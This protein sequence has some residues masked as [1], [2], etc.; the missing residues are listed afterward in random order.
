MTIFNRSM[1][2]LSRISVIFLTLTFNVSLWAEET[3]VS[4][5]DNLVTDANARTESVEVGKHVMANMDAGSMILS[6]VMVLG[7]IV[8]CAFLLKRFN[9]AHQSNEHLK[10]ISTLSLGPKERVVV[11]QAGK[12]QFLLG[13]NSA[14]NSGQI[15]V[16]DKLKQ[17]L[18]SNKSVNKKRSQVESLYKPST[19]SQKKPSVGAVLSLIK[20]KHIDSQSNLKE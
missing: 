8:V 7:L 3:T 16:I 6:L 12:E 17:T 11:I 2:M 5:N 4:T 14:S 19:S 13:I 15:T 1:R 20:N 18:D 10:L 9:V